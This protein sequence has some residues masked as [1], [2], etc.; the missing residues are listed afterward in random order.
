ML[1]TWK[2]PAL[3]DLRFTTSCAFACASLYVCLH[4]H[5]RVCVR[6]CVRASMNLRVCVHVLFSSYE[7][8]SVLAYGDFEMVPMVVLRQYQ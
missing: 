5:V 4:V 7:G 1:A 8:A 6:V 3:L 2:H